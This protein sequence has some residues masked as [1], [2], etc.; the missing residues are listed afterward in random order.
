[1][2]GG[3]HERSHRVPRRAREPPG[4]MAGR[5]ARARGRGGGRP[6][7]RREDRARGGAP[8]RRA[9]AAPADRGGIL[10]G[11]APAAHGRG[12]GPRARRPAA[13]RVD[14][15]A[16]PRGRPQPRAAVLLHRHGDGPAAD[17]VAGQVHFPSRVEDGGR[18][19]RGRRVRQVRRSAAPVRDHHGRLLRDDPRGGHARAGAPVRAPGPPQLRGQGVHGQERPGGLRRGDRGLAPGRGGAHRLVRGG[20]AA[21]AGPDGHHAAL[22][23]HVHA[24]APRGP[25]RDCR[26][27]RRRAR[28]VAHLRERRHG[29][30]RRRA[31]PGRAAG[32]A[33]LRSRGAADGPVRVC[34]RHAPR[35]GGAGAAGPEGRG[36]G[37]LPAEQLPLCRQVRPVP[38]RASPAAHPSSGTGGAPRKPSARGGRARGF[39]GRSGARIAPG[40][41]AAPAS[42][43]A[44]R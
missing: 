21:A 42:R 18:R 14:L 4:G 25:R 13:A 29:R 28:A 6:R 31:A 12:T 30:L 7:R 37:A 10:R 23:A 32:R 5:A 36:A 9:G 40:R 19:A 3:E 27:A 34:A 43:R 33:A 38:A 44:R 16:G 24:R 2:R 39:C 20:A 11:G 1:M 26:A 8:R 41:Y 17:A 22:R 15:D 35:A